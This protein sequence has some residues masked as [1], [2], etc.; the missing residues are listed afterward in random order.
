MHVAEIIKA[1]DK[2]IEYTELKASS[3]FEKK[4]KYIAIQTKYP[5]ALIH[6]KTICVD[7][8]WENVRN[9]RIKPVFET[10][11]HQVVRNITIQF[12]ISDNLKMPGVR[13]FA[14]TKPATTIAT[15]EF[16]FSAS[17]KK[18]ELKIANYAAIIPDACPN[19]QRFIFRI[20]K[21][22]FRQINLFNY[23]ISP[24]SYDLAIFEK[25]DM[26]R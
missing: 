21:Y 8:V 10:Q 13:V 6:R 2:D 18:A 19:K 17:P 26:L 24:S 14:G 4:N 7:D 25:W 12:P 16:D 3:L 15:V 23:K 1:I 20:R 22:L 11:D 5:N 9:M